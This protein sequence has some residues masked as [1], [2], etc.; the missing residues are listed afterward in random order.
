M[1]E[2]Q[3]ATCNSNKMKLV[4]FDMDGTIVN[5]I[6]SLSKAANLAL[7]EYGFEKH[8]RK[9]YISVIG[10][11]VRHFITESIPKE[12]R[13]DKDLVDDVCER[14]LKY[15][16]EYWDYNI[17]E[18]EGIHDLMLTLKSK[19]IKLAINT[20][21]PHHI[22]EKVYERFYNEELISEMIGSGDIYEKKPSPQG[23]NH[24]LNS[25]NILPEECLYVGDSGVDIE[26]A[27]KANIKSV[28]VDWG[29]GKKEDFNKADYIIHY[30]NQLLDIINNEN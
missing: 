13:I 29:Y 25:L 21:K 28:V 17:H 9:F 7:Q 14:Y 20:N 16:K 23:V 18:Y 10:Y 4:I 2:R 8:N 30:P 15:Y 11:G 1:K 19:K 24:I 3:K 12:Q 5:T 26:T 22:A 27:K 6:D